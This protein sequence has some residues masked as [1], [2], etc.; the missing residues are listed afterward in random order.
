MDLVGR[1]IDIIGLNF[2]YGVFG[3]IGFE[4]LRMYKVLTQGRKVLPKYDRKLFVFVMLGLG[5]FS[6][7]LASVMGGEDDAFR[8]LYVG[9]TLPTGIMAFQKTSE[10]Q[11]VQ[12]EVD[13]TYVVTPSLWQRFQKT[14]ARYFSY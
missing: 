10:K 7:M 6:G 9:F 2:F 3:F 12:V 5:L 13:D 11:Q 8:S 1:F 14:V 4:C